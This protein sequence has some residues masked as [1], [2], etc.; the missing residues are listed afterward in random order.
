MPDAQWPE[1]LCK[2]VPNRYEHLVGQLGV[3][4]I[5]HEAPSVSAL[6]RLLPVA[7]STC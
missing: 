5:G 2:H 6:G 3:M 4:P 7:P 1:L